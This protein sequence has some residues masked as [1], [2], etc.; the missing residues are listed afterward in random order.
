MDKTF[1]EIICI[2]FEKAQADCEQEAAC[3]AYRERL[4][5]MEENFRSMMMPIDYAY[6]E[7][8]YLP[9]CWE[10]EQEK[11]RWTYC[12]GFADGARILKKLG[13]F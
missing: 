1:A 8:D 6:F 11:L 3:H 12:R 13:A 4:G 9:A 10:A 5:E 7:E 2:L